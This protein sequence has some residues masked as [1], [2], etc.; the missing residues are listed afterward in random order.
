MQ[1]TAMT[2]PCAPAAEWWRPVVAAPPR[3]GGRL[4]FRALMAF[5]FIMVLAPQAYLPF[6][7]PLRIALLAA[8]AGIAARLVDSAVN[9]RPLS[10]GGREMTLAF[11]LLAWAVVTLPLSYW[12][13]GS[14]AL[15]TD[16]FFKTV[17]IFW[18]LANAVDTLPRLRRMAW[19]LVLM[20]VPLSLTGIRNFFSGVFIA[21]G[22]P[23][24][25]IG[26]Y[27]AGLTQNPNDLAL[28]LN[29]ILPLT[30]ALLL[31]SERRLPRAALAGIAALQVAAVVVT[32]SRS[33]F[34]TLATIGAVYL[35]RMLRSG[36]VLGAAALVGAALL[37][38]AL[39]PAGHL[40]RLATIG[41][42]DSDPTG[43]AQARWRDTVAAT[44][45][46]L[47]HPFTGAGLGMNTLAL[48]EVRGPAWTMVHNVYLEY[49]A[50]LGLPG[51]LLFL[52]LMASCLLRARRA[53][54]CAA[55]VAGRASLS[56]LGGGIEAALLG[57]AVAA[58][59]YP[60]AYHFY[61]YYLAGLAV[62]AG[63]LCTTAPTAEPATEHA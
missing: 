13:G 63:T 59:F 14:A 47:A 7:R 42:I 2:T 32:F 27:E 60:V 20:A 52:W 48:N 35:W 31:T 50:D 43:S 21:A 25:R 33:G 34:L 11:L 29:T 57:F 17:A 56:A 36:R 9:G 49:A 24:K 46:V 1:V 37:A 58:F 26:G 45:F 28:M 10:V 12:P 41:D 16:R 22:D 38:L 44:Q 54:R 15:L 23:V 40:G 53:R 5:T 8:V 62:A 18:L 19:G 30:V 4:A 6:L 61:F 39:A 51:L 3:E 55:G